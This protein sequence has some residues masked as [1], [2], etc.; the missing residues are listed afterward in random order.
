M[1][2]FQRRGAERGH[3]HSAT[4]SHYCVTGLN[5]DEATEAL[6]SSADTWAQ[7]GPI[8]PPAR[9]PLFLQ[10]V[11]SCIRLWGG[12]RAILTHLL[13]CSPL[14]AQLSPIFFFSVQVVLG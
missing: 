6:S 10:K 12:N 11:F 2:F 8:C 13:I 3:G 4:H 14:L 7:P 1:S 9:T 5:P